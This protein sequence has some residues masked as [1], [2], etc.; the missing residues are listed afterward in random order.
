MNK[1]R[2]LVAD[3]HAVVRMGFVS[4]LESE[5]DIEVVAEAGDGE[6]AVRQA[7]ATR[8]DVVLMD[9][10]M[11]KLNGTVATAKIKVKHPETKVL[12][13]TSSGDVN[14]I[15]R[16]ID[17]GADGALMKND[18]YAEVVGALRALALGERVISPVIRKMLNEQAPTI[19]LSDRQR[20]VLEAMCRG[21]TNADIAKLLAISPD[22]VKFHI[23]A[24]FTKLD[25][26]N[27]SEA[28]S[29]ALRN[30]LVKL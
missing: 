7:H 21:L 8:P 15:G 19:V 23:T 13:L 1:I 22:G 26:A 17:A 29:I 5:P 30:Q 10:V 20:E 9:L 6:I 24:I 4:L 2:I 11:P 28:I 18:D 14:E 16:A 3:D 12:I 27:R 25:V